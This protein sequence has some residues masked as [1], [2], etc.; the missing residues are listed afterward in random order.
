MRQMSPAICVQAVVL[1][2]LLALAVSS[3][4]DPG[5]AG[6]LMMVEQQMDIAKRLGI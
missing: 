5:Q 2:A 3:S 4:F 1:D 6:I